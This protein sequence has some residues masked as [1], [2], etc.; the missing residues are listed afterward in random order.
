MA[1]TK[2]LCRQILADNAIFSLPSTVAPTQLVHSERDHRSE[3]TLL[4]TIRDIFRLL[5]KLKAAQ[6]WAP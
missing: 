5:A 1:I 3:H 6:Q 2:P 4:L